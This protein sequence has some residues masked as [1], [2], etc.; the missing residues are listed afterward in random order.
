MSKKMVVA[1]QV[2]PHRVIRRAARRA[3]RALEVS[4]GLLPRWDPSLADEPCSDSEFSG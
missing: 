4:G 1:A 3:L 2:G